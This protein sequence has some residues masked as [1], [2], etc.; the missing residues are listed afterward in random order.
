MF[1]HQFRDKY[2]STLSSSVIPVNHGSFG[3]VPSPVYD[4]YLSKLAEYSEFPD[5]FFNL[6]QKE[7]Y[8]DSLKVLAQVLHCDYRDLAMVDNATTALATVLR[9]FPFQAGDTFVYH[10]TGYGPSKNLL[11]FMR[12]QY[13]I[14]LV[15]VKITY[16]ISNKEIVSKFKEAFEIHKPKLCMFDVISS[17]PG[18]VM[19][20]VE[21]I[22]LC[23]QYDVLSLVDGAHAIGNIPQDLGKLQPDFYTSLMHKWYF[24]PRPSAVLYVNRKHHTKVQAFPT[25]DYSTKEDVDENILIDK[26]SFWVYRHHVSIWTVPDAQ[27]FRDEVCGGEE[28][29]YNYCHSLAMEV[30]KLISEEWGTSYLDDEDQ[31]STMV[32]V[33]VPVSPKLLENWTDVEPKFKKE[34]F[35]KNTFVPCVIHNGK[36]YARFSCQIF[37]EISDYQ[38]ASKLLLEVLQQLEEIYLHEN[39]STSLSL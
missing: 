14:N 33:E 30:G 15:E 10:S 18:T 39:F 1:G 21:L 2:F 29:I 32:N 35:G 38:S 17:M 12:D 34:L 16:P 19:P 37:N 3:T 13:K 31:I 23:K 27:K 26:F 20:Y 22:Q 28:N 5:R 36:L 11:Y 7:V 8:V 24:V 25:Y 9:S 4:V 6:H